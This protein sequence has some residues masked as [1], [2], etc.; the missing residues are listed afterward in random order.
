VGVSGGLDSVVL[1]HVLHAVAQRQ[2]LQLSAVHV[3]H[4]IS[5]NSARWA[6]F[7][8]ARCAAL[9]IALHSVRV[10]VPRDTGRGLEAAARAA[11]YAVF[12]RQD[13]DAIALAHHLDDQA[14]TVLLQLLRG[15][16]A[17]GLAGMPEVRG[18]GDSPLLLLRPL[19][20][21]PRK[22]IE[23]Y[24]RSRSL[25]WVE[26]ESNRSLDFDRN[27]LRHEV[28]P[29]IG[30]RFP[31]YRETW[32]RASRNLAGL[33]EIA[34]DLARMDAAQAQVGE[35]LR[36]SALRALS[37]A[38][39]LNLLRWFLQAQSVPAQ[40]RERLEEALAQILS[41]AG[42]RSPSI[43]MGP[44]ALRRYR[45]RI[46]VAGAAPLPGE[47]RIVWRGED[48]LALPPGYGRLR[49][50]PARGEGLHAARL[51]AAQVV[52]A[53]RRGGERIKPSAN[54]PQ[55]SLKNVLSEAGLPPWER[56]RLP[57]LF[58]GDTLA[59]VPGVGWDCRMGAQPDE[60]GL[61]P[62]WVREES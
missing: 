38:R 41:A 3:D 37:P 54:R 19:L 5:G 51:R 6:Q 26:D 43:R 25:E 45:G 2:P 40:P 10:D 50:R 24:A 28:L 62:E 29:R 60:P 56:E 21:V 16:G 18:L 44:V 39:R 30:A 20:E 12:A 61:V 59:W 31:A 1:L 34:Q 47:W 58:C 8:A 9:G 15:A 46:E 35:A 52:I 33:D 23:D 48:E 36:V 55:R 7:C 13:A 27:Y 53:P 32:L 11:R 42:D 17:P 49:F 22:Q 57:L 14:E 4:G